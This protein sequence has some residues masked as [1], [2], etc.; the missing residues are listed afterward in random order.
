MHDVIFALSCIFLGGAC[1]F[2]WQMKL[3][4]DQI[5]TNHALDRDRLHELSKR[6]VEFIAKPTQ[7]ATD[8]TKLNEK[9]AKL[10]SLHENL[11]NKVTGLALIKKL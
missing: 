10:E 8:L 1:S 2:L 11:N 5:E 6:V 9:I 4:V 7:A 3:H